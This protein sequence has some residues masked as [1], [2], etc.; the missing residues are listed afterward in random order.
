MPLGAVG[1]AILLSPANEILGRKMAIIIST[2]LYTIG[3]ALS[4]GSINYGICYLPQPNA[5]Y[6]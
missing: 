4:A 3:A 5:I 2:V 1:G 6:H